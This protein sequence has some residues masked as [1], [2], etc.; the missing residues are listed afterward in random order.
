MKKT[1]ALG[2][3][4]G[5]H[6]G[7]MAVLRGASH[8]LLFDIHPQAFLGRNN[9]P[10]KLLQDGLRD[11]LLADIDVIPIHLSFAKIAEFSP[12][13][14][15]RKIII[16]QLHATGVICGFDFH[17]GKNAVGD[18][19]TLAA[20]C[21]EHKIDCQVIPP[22]YWQGKA[23]SSTRIRRALTQ[24]D[25][26]GANAMLGRP[27]AYRLPVLSGAARGRTL[28]YP[29]ANQAFPADFIV[30]RRGVYA[31]RVLIG[32]QSYS[33]MTNIGLR[34]TFNSAEILSETYIFDFTGDLYGQE[35]SVELL[36]FTRDER[37]FL[38]VD[39]LIEQLK[40]DE[41][42]CK[43][44][45]SLSAPSDLK[46]GDK[47]RLDITSQ[48]LQGQGVGRY[49]GL[50]V[51]VPA[52]AAG[53]LL[54][55][56]TLKREK[57]L[58][59]GRIDEIITP[60]SQR[61]QQNCSAYPR[62]GGCVFR[63]IN[64]D[65]ELR[66]KAQAV[67]DALERLG[68]L[69]T[70]VLPIIP[71]PATE[72]YRNKG[73]FVVVQRENALL[74]GFY[75][76]RS[77]RVIPCENCLLQPPEFGIIIQEILEHARKYAIS[78]YDENR[79]IGILRHIYLRKSAKTSEILV[80]LVTNTDKP[81][82]HSNRLYEKL[83]KSYPICGLLQNINTKRGNVILGEYTHSLHGKNRLEDDVLGIKLEISPETFYQVNHAQAERLYALATKE[84]QL[85]GREK[86]L[87]LHCGSGL[88]GLVMAEKCAE[89][90]GVEILP[91]ATE[92]AREN[93]ARNGIKNARFIC[94]DAGSG[95]QKLLAEGFRPD[96]VLL[97]P[98]R[99]GCTHDLVDTV[100]AAAPMRVV[101]LSC[102]PAT[103]ARDCALF[104]QRGYRLA[105][106]TPV[107]MFPRT[108]HVET[109]ALLQKH[110]T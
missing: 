32:G 41:A 20:L 98:P 45:Q 42:M 72:H 106:V 40:K 100:C 27:F 21:Q 29:T 49:D 85:T 10:A 26:T 74:V 17:F 58:A 11:K 77:H 19:N 108:G 43:D 33:A 97:D 79:H 82:R 5:L 61:I 38:G 64:Y 28:G 63:H 46:K 60:S 54:E 36:R 80:T 81:V 66:I 16:E 76:S 75:A 93:A 53:D 51:F 94:A 68:K 62:C 109:V 105:R 24:G 3:F 107:D 7:H 95:A 50:A 18:T 87:E 8:C 69:E 65:E 34:P 102:N 35:I 12:E 1:I 25:I 96:V 9:P 55:V 71:A 48:T 47:I 59:Y 90:V 6:I 44:G 103:L 73:Q 99:A 37:A 91:Q 56:T 13:E 86:L 70:Q 92:N 57:R 67:S 39:E 101:Y 83:R 89:L 15:F 30:P 4:D 2:F 22:I 110:D 104:A 88:L 23:V 52:A 78:A 14:F 31:S 84:A